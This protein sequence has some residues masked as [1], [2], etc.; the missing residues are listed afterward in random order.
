ML[1]L[2]S[3]YTYIHTFYFKSKIHTKSSEK[4]SIYRVG[5]MGLTYIEET[6]NSV[7]EREIP[8]VLVDKI[9]SHITLSVPTYS[10]YSKSVIFSYD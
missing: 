7:R 8:I 3:C 1:S 9:R 5:A 2:F 6:L 4:F 10:F